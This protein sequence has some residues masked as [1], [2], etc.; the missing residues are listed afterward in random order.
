MTDNTKSGNTTIDS[1]ETTNGGNESFESQ[2]R[3]P[4]VAKA[5]SAKPNRDRMPGDPA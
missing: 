1:V 5:E 3:E 4:D 2:D